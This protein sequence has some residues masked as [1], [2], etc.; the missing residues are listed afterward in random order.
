MEIITIKNDHQE[1]E[2]ERYIKE[3]GCVCYKCGTIFIFKDFE[4]NKPRMINYTKHDC[5]I[6][7]PNITCKTRIPLDH[8][9]VIEFNKKFGKAD[10][11]MK[12]DE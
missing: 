1:K 4:V 3:Y 6:T 12:Y 7:C 8:K 11:K 2:Y 5:S 10:F 9:N